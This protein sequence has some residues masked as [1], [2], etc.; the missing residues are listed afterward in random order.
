MNAETPQPEQP[1]EPL[2]AVE[3]SSPQKLINPHLSGS[4][5]S[6]HAALQNDL[7]QAQELAADFQR[8]LAGKSNEYA[9]L[10]QILEKTQSDLAHLQAG[11]M[12]LRAERHCLANE[13]MKAQALEAIRKTLERKLEEQLVQ[14]RERDR[15][16]ADLVIE[17]VRLHQ[18][19]DEMR[20]A[21]AAPKAVTVE[22]REIEITPEVPRPLRMVR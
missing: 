20:G 11:I 18:V 8:Q 4:L 12:Q 3:S 5:A 15:R 21:V 16:I 17:T 10:K 22:E 13:A 7:L 9:Q 6:D 1:A 14:L 2:A 19:L